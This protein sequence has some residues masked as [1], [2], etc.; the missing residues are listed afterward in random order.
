MGSIDDRFGVTPGEVIATSPTIP[1]IDT[2]S[3][4]DA[5]ALSD[6]FWS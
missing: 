2:R 3:A 6:H 1:I 4:T 5:V